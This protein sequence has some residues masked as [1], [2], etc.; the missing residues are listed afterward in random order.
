MTK[1][2]FKNKLINICS[3]HGLSIN[4][5]DYYYEA[6]THPSY[7]NEHNVKSYERLEFLGDA[8]LGYLVAEYMYLTKEISEGQMTKLRANYVCEAANSD[9]SLEL[10]LNNVLLLGKGA[11]AHHEGSVAVLGDIFESFLGALYLDHDITYVKN[12]LKKFLFPKIKTEAVDFFVD[13][14]SEL[15]EYIQAES[16]QGVTYSLMSESG[17]AHNKTFEAAV[18]HENVKLG[19]GIGKSKK[20]AEQK[21]AKD[22]LEKLVR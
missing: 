12:F 13:Y 20:E 10:G 14:K 15:Q 22:A 21:A 19:S 17:P 8:I 1:N 16:R 18:W 2:E 7:A 5:I 9:Y 6:L 3:K 4:E 11:T